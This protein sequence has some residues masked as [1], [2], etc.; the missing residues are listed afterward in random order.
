MVPFGL[1]VVNTTG[2]NTLQ[3]LTTKCL[4][5]DFLNIIK[6]QL[7]QKI[8]SHHN[9]TQPN[10]HHLEPT[11]LMEVSNET[12]ADASATDVEKI[13]VDLEKDQEIEKDDNEVIDETAESVSPPLARSTPALLTEAEMKRITKYSQCTAV[14]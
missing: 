1:C 7:K 8:T 4:W 13:E 5:D 12:E 9:P 10:L 14:E 2:T 6:T 3:P 11:G